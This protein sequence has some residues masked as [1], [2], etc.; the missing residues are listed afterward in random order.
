MEISLL[1]LSAGL[2]LY[3]KQ[4]EKLYEAYMTGDVAVTEFI[5]SHH[6]RLRKWAQTHCSYVQVTPADI[7]LA[8]SDWYYFDSW[9]HLVEWVALVTQRNSPVFL[10]ESAVEAIFS[11]DAAA[12]SL[13]LKEEPGLVKMRSMRRHHGTL[14]HYVGAN[15]VEYYRAQYPKNAVESLKLL[16]D[17]GADLNATADM[18]GGGCTPLGLVATSVH[19]T[20]AGVM[21]SLL[22]AMLEGGAMM[23]LPGIAGNAAGLINGCLANGR[24][25]AADFLARRGAWLNLEGAAGVGRL[26][27]V[28]SFFNEDG[29]LNK[30]ATQR[31]LDRGFIWASE[32]GQTAVVEYLLEK[33]VDPSLEVDGMNSLHWAVIGGHLDTIKLL[34]DRG[35]SL[36]SVN[37]YGGT[38]LGAAL[39]ATVNSASVFRW[40]A[41]TDDLL[42][43]DLLLS[44][45]SQVEE[46]TLGWLQRQELSAS[47]K[48]AIADLLRNHGAES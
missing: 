33:G 27:V 8:M 4:A 1:P 19:P 2:E 32:F 16:L 5:Q 21:Y 37:V 48:A 30:D 41:S 47:K 6:P 45:G 43:I 11:G 38:A 22:G 14:L 39:W 13:L 15:G 25:E 34:I 3:R 9:M 23:D 28:R 29:S 17:G 24:P 20:K 26:D 12:L 10:F 31:D 36:E 44:E 42:V 40:P 46:G 18:Y 35:V 7:Q